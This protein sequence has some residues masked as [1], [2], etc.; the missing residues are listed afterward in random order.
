MKD[1]KD[2]EARGKE[3]EALRE[4]YEAPQLTAVGN[5]REILA[6]ETGSIAD[7]TCP[8]APTRAS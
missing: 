2:S 6:G 8:I 4:P 7:G 5:A 3:G 1:P